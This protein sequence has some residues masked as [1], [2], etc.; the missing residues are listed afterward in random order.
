[1]KNI[2]SYYSK[3]NLGKYL[4]S[5]FSE[6]THN[7]KYVGNKKEVP[8]ENFAENRRQFLYMHYENK[9]DHRIDNALFSEKQKKIFETRLSKNFINNIRLVLEILERA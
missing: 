9:K 6:H 1:M 5:T 8:Q 3:K 7:K 2:E 4:N